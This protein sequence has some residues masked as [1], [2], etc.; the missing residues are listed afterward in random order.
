MKHGRRWL[1]AAAV[2]AGMGI[3][4]AA[5]AEEVFV[6]LPQAN[7]LAGKGAGAER[8]AQVK[9]GEKLTVLGHEGSWLK[10]KIGDRE[11]YVHEN[12]V[13]TSGGGGGGL[14]KFLGDASGS[15]AASSAEAGRGLGESMAWARSTGMNTG[16]LERML[17]MRQDVKG[18]DWENFVNQG[19]VGPAK[20]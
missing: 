19:H 13:G 3:A 12:S 20:K 2:T 14:G 5:K 4:G 18:S 9:K 6:K 16:G 11:G 10:V 17:A 8:L 15:S 1:I 7:I